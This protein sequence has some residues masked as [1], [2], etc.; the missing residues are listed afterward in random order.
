VASDLTGG[1]IARPDAASVAQPLPPRSAQ[2]HRRRFLMV[3]S[4]LVLAVAAAVVG[5]VVFAARSINPAPRWSTWKP[6]GAGLGAAKQ[7]AERVSGTYHLASGDQLVD[8]IAKTPSVSVGKK[9]LPISFIA[10]RAKGKVDQVQD[11]SPST[12]VWYSLCGLGASCS[13]ATGTPSA[14][15]GTLVRREVLELALYTFKYVKGVQRVVA[16]MPPAN[17]QQPPII[18]YLQKNDVAAQLKRPLTVT[19]GSKVPL[20]EMISA[21][22][23]R[24]IDSATRSRLYKIFGLPQTPQGDWV[25][26]LAHIRA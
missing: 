21:R 12:S 22:E 19:I 16:F 14:W 6:S 11:V 24:T 20:P 7:I 1:K 4:L 18:V 23:Q 5:V 13:I 15:R 26:A 10:L 9:T 2:P 8:V 3:Y 17:A 25:L